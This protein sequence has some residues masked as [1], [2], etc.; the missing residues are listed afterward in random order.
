MNEVCLGVDVYAL[1]SE[2]WACLSTVTV[3]NNY[4]FGLGPPRQER[5]VSHYTISLSALADSGHMAIGLIL[6]Y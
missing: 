2:Q 6:R 1:Q 5:L 4:I 3:I